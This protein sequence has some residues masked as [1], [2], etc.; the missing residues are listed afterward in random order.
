MSLHNFTLYKA[1]QDQIDN[2]SDAL[3]KLQI[4]LV[5][6]DRESVMN[7]F[8]RE[9]TQSRKKQLEKSMD[10][11]QESIFFLRNIQSTVGGLQLVQ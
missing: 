8:S 2:L 11:I 4:Q 5:Y 3:V 9:V 7:V 1:Y 10:S 6:I